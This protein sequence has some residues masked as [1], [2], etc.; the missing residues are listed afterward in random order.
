MR[1]TFLRAQFCILF[2]SYIIASHFV[3][4]YNERLNSMYVLHM[5]N[6]VL[7]CLSFLKKVLNSFSIQKI[8]QKKLYFL[9]L[10]DHGMNVVCIWKLEFRL[11]A[12]GCDIFCYRQ[13]ITLINRGCYFPHAGYAF[14]DIPFSQIIW[15]EKVS[16][17][18][19]ICSCTKWQI[20]NT[21]GG[22]D[23]R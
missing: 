9:V 19:M 17:L 5:A 1:W 13:G 7:N 23:W 16:S 6:Y 10:W 22:V 21:F 20:C 18:G 4:V 11:C 12:R 3:S 2:I 8:F 14:L 15:L